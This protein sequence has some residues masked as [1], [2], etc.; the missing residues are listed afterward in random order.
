MT[1]PG[2]SIAAPVAES[3]DWKRRVRRSFSAVSLALSIASV[4][5]MTLLG[6]LLAGWLL[7]AVL[8]MGALLLVQLP[9]FWMCRLLNFT[10]ERSPGMT[11]QCGR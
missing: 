10:P 1:L 3:S 2:L 4:P 5:G 7:P 11:T 8:V 9:L 6:L